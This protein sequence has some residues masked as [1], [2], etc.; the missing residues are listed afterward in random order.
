MLL[1]GFYLLFDAPIH[2]LGKDDVSVKAD[3]FL[4]SEIAVGTSEVM[5]RNKFISIVH[6]T[7]PYYI[8]GLKLQTALMKTHFMSRRSRQP[9][10]ATR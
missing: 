3:N 1:S 10:S 6:L 5:N 4:M 9:S 8:N 2:K 7:S